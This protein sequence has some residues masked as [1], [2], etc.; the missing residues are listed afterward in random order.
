MGC[1]GRCIWMLIPA[2]SSFATFSSCLWLCSAVR[3]MLEPEHL[4]DRPLVLIGTQCPIEIPSVKPRRRHGR[5]SFDCGPTGNLVQH[6]DLA[7]GVAGLHLPT[8]SPSTS[9]LATPESTTNRLL[10]SLPC[11]VSRLSSTPRFEE[12]DLGNAPQPG[13]IHSRKERNHASMMRPT[14]RSSTCPRSR[15]PESVRPS[16][17]GPR[18][19]S[20]RP[21]SCLDRGR[22]AR[23]GSPR[24]PWR[25]ADCCGAMPAPQSSIPGRA[26]PPDTPRSQPGRDPRRSRKRCPPLHPMSRRRHPSARTCVKP[27]S[28]G[29]PGRPCRVHGKGVRRRAAQR[30]GCG[31]PP[32]NR[33]RPSDDAKTPT[34]PGASVLR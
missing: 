30:F 28:P 31:R 21:R 6:G 15:P 8:T 10:S 11:T 13:L 29:P 14:R 5:H 7:E 16:C 24:R 17:G 20:P 1:L 4:L 23:A 9:T 33:S 26:P 34:A 22:R 19:R 3:E 32:P 2:L 18:C 12:A 27:G 25:L